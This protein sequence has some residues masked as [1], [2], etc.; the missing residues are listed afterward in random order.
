MRYAVSFGTNPSSLE[1]AILYSG[2]SSYAAAKSAPV[3][4][5]TEAQGIVDSPPDI[6]MPKLPSS[7]L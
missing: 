2:F 4:M 7:L 5:V 3:C 1:N 6:S